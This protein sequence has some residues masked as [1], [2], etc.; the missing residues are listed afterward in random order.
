MQIIELD[1]LKQ[2]E[3]NLLKIFSK[4]CE[5]NKLRYF[6]AYGTLIGAV[7]HKGFIPWD[8]DIDVLMPRPDFNRFIQLMQVNDL[9]EHVDVLCPLVSPNYT[10]PFIKVVDKRTIAY[11]PLREEKDQCGVWVDVFPMDGIPTSEIMSRWLF[12]KARIYRISLQLSFTS[13]LHATST[14]RKLVKAPWRFF[15]K[16]LGYKR[17]L[18]KLIKNAVKYSYNDEAFV[19]CVVWNYG[20]KEKTLKKCYEKY[21]SLQFENYFFFAGQGYHEIL[22]RIYGD[23]MQLP[24]EEKRINHHLKAFWR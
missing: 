5:Q 9:E 16:K 20:N 7:R 24:P 3:L 14:L 10:F 2:I 1:E 17:I 21:V 4:F 15:C 19:G 18:E 6:L 8:D 22:T 23:Y 11:E 13:Q 12:F